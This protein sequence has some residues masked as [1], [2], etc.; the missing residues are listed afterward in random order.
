MDYT[1]LDT[2]AISFAGWTVQVASGRGTVSDA[3]G[4]DVAHFDVEKDGN[5]SLLE[6]DNK[7]KD[8]ALI[9]VRS[10]VRYE[11]PQTV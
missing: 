4:N 3:K 8:L 5:I 1:K 11:A 9:A 7:F 10:F 2:G 6:G